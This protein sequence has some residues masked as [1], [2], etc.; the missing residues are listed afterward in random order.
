MRGNSRA[1]GLAQIQTDVETLGVKGLSQDPEGPIQ[2]LQEIEPF[3]LFEI[4]K[5]R[6]VTIRNHHQVTVGVGIT[7]QEKEAVAG[8]LKEKILSV[9]SGSRAAAPAKKAALF[10]PVAEE[11]D[12]SPRS[13]DP[14]HLKNDLQLT[15]KFEKGI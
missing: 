10:L 11:V 12:F 7:I 3:L 5:R 15:I 13:P 14:V 2:Q 9:F 4:L 6:N 1:A 8:A